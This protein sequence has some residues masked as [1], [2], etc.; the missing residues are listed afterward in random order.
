ML[1]EAINA[2]LT[3]A[4]LPTA[5]ATK[6]GADDAFAATLLPDA[7]PSPAELGHARTLALGA[8]ATPSPTAP[9][10]PRRKQAGVRAGSAALVALALGA[11]RY[12]AHGAA[13]IVVAPS[14]VSAPAPPAPLRPHHR[15]PIW[16]H[17]R[18][19]SCTSPPRPPRRSSSS[20]TPRWRTPSPAPL[21]APQ[22]RTPSRCAPPVTGP[23]SA[24][25]ILDGDTVLAITLHAHV[26]EDA[27]KAPVHVVKNG[28][29][30][31]GNE[32]PTYH[33]VQ[34]TLMNDYPGAK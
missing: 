6:P 16:P 4:P 32:P 27:P 20:M 9:R 1:G 28:G 29:R 14:V 15:A 24:S 23:S 18:R 8:A 17:P 12:S 3:G 10:K 30:A 11:W 7:L 26:K 33:G 5:T 13:P 31:P 21:R 34:G 19:R 22:P 2:A 25:L